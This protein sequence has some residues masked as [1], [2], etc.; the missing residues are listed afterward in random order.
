VNASRFLIPQIIGVLLLAGRLTATAAETPAADT[1]RERAV[2]A[3]EQDLKTDPNN[4]ELWVHLGFAHRKM[5]KLD[6]AQRAFE[7]A[8]AL[9]PRAT[10]ALY[11]LGLI[12]ESKHDQKAAEKA[13]KDYLAAETDAEKRAIAEKHIHHLTQ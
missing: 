9:N 2:S 6:D 5:G 3:L 7:K 10:E 12:Y 8:A 4:A 11:M 1:Q 13:W